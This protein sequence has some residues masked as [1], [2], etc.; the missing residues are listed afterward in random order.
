[1]SNAYEGISNSDADLAKAASYSGDPWTP[2]NRYFEMAEVHMP[3][4]WS[5]L[6]L[7]FIGD[8]DF[9]ATLDLAAGHGRNSEYL[10]PLCDTLAITDIQP[11]NVAYCQQRFAGHHN[12]SCFVGNGYDFKP[13]KDDSLTL[14]YCF[15][16]MVHFEPKVVESYIVDAFR[17]LR[18]G[19]MAFFHHSND[20]GSTDWHSNRGSRNRMTKE[21]F[22]SIAAKARLSVVKQQVIDWGQHKALDCLSLLQKPH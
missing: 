3:S 21:T 17:V 14:I 10:A 6:I 7:P 9:T 5:K 1:M 19:G 8:C 22:A 12:V 11:G 20:G 16:A 18:P 4:M 2:E 13:Q 15:D